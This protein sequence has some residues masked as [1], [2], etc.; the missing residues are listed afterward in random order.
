MKKKLFFALIAIL[1][2]GLM[3]VGCSN[4]TTNPPP[5]PPSAFDNLTALTPD[6]IDEPASLDYVPF[7]KGTPKDEDGIGGSGLL[8]NTA[9]F[10]NDGGEGYIEEGDAEGE[11]KVMVVPKPGGFSAIYFQDADYVYKTGFYLSLDLPQADG[12]NNTHK[13]IGMTAFAAT[14]PQESGSN[15]WTSAQRVNITDANAV[16]QTNKYL[17]GRVDFSWENTTNAWPR[18]TIALYI[19]WHTDEDAATEYTFT[20]RKILGNPMP[21]LDEPLY[22]NTAWLPTDDISTSEPTDGWTDFPSAGV[23]G[24]T[25]AVGSTTGSCSAALVSGEYELTVPTS[26]TNTQIVIPAS[27]D[28]V[29]TDGYYMSVELPDNIASN[30]LRP[31]RF[32][33]TTQREGVTDWSPAIDAT[34]PVDSYVAGNFSII[35]KLTA[36]NPYDGF[37]IQLDW[38]PAEPAGGSYTFTIKKLKVTDDD[39]TPPDPPNEIIPFDPTIVA[40]PSDMTEL[41]EDEMLGMFKNWDV[42]AGDIVKN[43]DDTYNVTIN[44]SGTVPRIRFTYDAGT[45]DEAYLSF[46]FPETDGIRP[47]QIKVFAGSDDSFNNELGWPWYESPTDAGNYYGAQLD[48]S[49]T[50]AGPAKTIIIYLY[51]TDSGEDYEFTINKISVKESL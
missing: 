49:Q 42:S 34:A 14:G 25:W 18:R 6:P 17:A 11:Y 45:F 13:P 36:G 48:I 47:T 38:H 20:V 39:Y 22:P 31:I 10:V 29:F 19:Y 26:A 28:F 41:T 43:V 16:D 44:S 27:G 32:Y 30:A 7:V 12:V 5:N 24:A 2:V 1:T 46:T 35:K 3:F 8:G 37:Y 40:E 50:F 21:D 4:G 9:F 51:L 23:L 15:D 33:V